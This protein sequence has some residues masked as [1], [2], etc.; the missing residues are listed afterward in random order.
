[1]VRRSRT[2]GLMATSDSELREQAQAEL[3]EAAYDSKIEGNVDLHAGGC[4]DQLD[5][6]ELAV[7]DADG[8]GLLRDRVDGDRPRRAST[9]R[10]SGRR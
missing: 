3:V 9:S 6:Q 2:M 8:A 4:G 10:A 5:A 1:M 7:A